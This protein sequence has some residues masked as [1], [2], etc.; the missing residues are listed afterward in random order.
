MLAAAWY[1]ETLE[2]ALRRALGDVRRAARGPQQAPRC[3]VCGAEAQH[4]RTLDGG[5]VTT[6]D[7]CGS[8]LEEDPRPQ[9]R[10]L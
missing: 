7:S 4:D 10:L 8:V 9:L 5:R 2:D 1:E 3:I 6:C